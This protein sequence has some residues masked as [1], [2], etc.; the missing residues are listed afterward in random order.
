MRADAGS[1]PAIQPAF[2]GVPGSRGSRGT[3]PLTPEGLSKSELAP[4]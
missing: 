1:T 4:T 3:A 2:R